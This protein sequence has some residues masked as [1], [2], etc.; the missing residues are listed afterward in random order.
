MLFPCT[1]PFFRYFAVKPKLLRVRSVGSV[2]HPPPVVKPVPANTTVVA[3]F[4]VG[5]VQDLLLTSSV[6]TIQLS[7][8]TR[9]TL[10]VPVALPSYG[11]EAVSVAVQ[12]P[13]GVV[14]VVSFDA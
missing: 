4:S 9:L 7:A 8:P 11:E 3:V 2:I 13:F 1:P 12:V 5:A 14:K 10:Q 6:L